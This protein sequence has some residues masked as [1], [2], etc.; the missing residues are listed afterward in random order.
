MPGWPLSVTGRG[1]R[2]VES[3][4]WIPLMADSFNDARVAAGCCKW[5]TNVMF[6]SARSP[7]A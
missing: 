4:R 2:G 7:G 5:E 1:V 6:G 3:R